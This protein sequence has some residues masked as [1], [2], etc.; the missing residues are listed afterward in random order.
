VQLNEQQELLIQR[1]VDDEL[2]VDDARLLISG[3]DEIDDGWKSLACG[4][5][6]DRLLTKSIRD[7]SQTN[8]SFDHADAAYKTLPQIAS[9]SAANRR[10]NRGWFAHPVTS[11]TLCAAIAFVSGL[12]IPHS[13]SQSSSDTSRMI[14]E[15]STADENRNTVAP[16]SVASQAG[17]SAAVPRYQV[18]WLPP[19][20]GTQDPVQIPV[21]QGVS[22]W[23]HGLADD[24][25]LFGA[26][27]R[28]FTIGGSGADAR[29]IRI[30]LNDSEDILLLVREQDIGL[31]LQ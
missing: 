27:N 25:Q 11:L 23:A 28:G 7:I 8:S 2:S 29:L 5:L 13:P 24:P 10:V 30:P 26:D 19:G 17:G 12:L 18:E 31:P 14:A 20:Q 4:L 6:E 9:T 3:M 16:G 22:G 15:A 21:F 1:C